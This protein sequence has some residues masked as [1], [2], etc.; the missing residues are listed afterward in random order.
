MQYLSLD[1]YKDGFLLVARILLAIL[2]VLFGWQKMMGF[3]GTVGYMTSV[4]APLPQLSAIIAVIVELVFG[5][6]IVA[7]YFTRP[8]ALLL[9]VY[10][11]ATAIIGH[12]YWNMTGMD[13]YMAMTNF[14]K[15]VSIC[16]GFLLLAFTG[17]GRYSL[18]RR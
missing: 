13:Q 7:G 10:T 5:L 17:P 2:F 1:K 12:P 4:G 11:V 8:L 3:E 14:F 18:D 9:A 16:G 6:L 15:N